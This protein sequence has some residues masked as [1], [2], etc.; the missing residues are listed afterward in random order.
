MKTS[1][2][3]WTRERAALLAAVCLVAG[4]AAGWA[5]GGLRSAKSWEAI[6]AAAVMPENNA[7]QKPTTAPSPAQLKGLADAQAAP[8]MEKLKSD[9]NNADVLAMLG[10][11]YYDAQQYAV[12]VDYYARALRVRPAD[13]AMRTDMGTGFWFM[14]NTDRAIAEFEKALTYVPDNPNTLFNLGL[15]KW[16]GKKDGAGAAAAWERLLKTDPQYEQKGQVEQMLAEVRSQGSTAV[17]SQ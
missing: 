10:N 12:A 15:V 16:R 4:T 1:G 5:I 9:P 14:G 8:L 13:A 17:K 3:R 11:L 6:P 2:M 7:A